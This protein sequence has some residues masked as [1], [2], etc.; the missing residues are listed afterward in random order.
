MVDHSRRSLRLARVV[1]EHHRLAKQQQPLPQA[2]F[3]VVFGARRVAVADGREVHPN[4]GV[5]H[6]TR[7]R[8][9]IL[10]S[11]VEARV[12]PLHGRARG[13]G[14]HAATPVGDDLAAVSSDLA[15][16]AV[17]DAVHA[18]QP[19]VGAER[20]NGLVR[21]VSRLVERRVT[22]GHVVDGVDGAGALVQDR[23]EEC[24]QRWHGG[25]SF[26][27]RERKRFG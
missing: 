19:V 2:P 1:R 3:G 8:V 11:D 16:D 21:L 15:A 7:C 5:D 6:G 10:L 20:G 26:R 14:H 25:C 24:W 12:K 13:N 23:V 17:V 18:N 9:R 4:R 22:I 27:E